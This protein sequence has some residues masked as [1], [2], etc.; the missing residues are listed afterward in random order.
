MVPD[1]ESSIRET[2]DPSGVLESG[3]DCQFAGRGV[4]R[5]QRIS[6]L[7]QRR[8]GGR[9]YPPVWAHLEARDVPVAEFDFAA[10]RLGLLV[11]RDQAAVLGVTAREDDTPA[12]GSE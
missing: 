1:G 2:R 9:N 5:P 4:P 11:P 8:G 3:N 6:L 12:A 10:G 7:V